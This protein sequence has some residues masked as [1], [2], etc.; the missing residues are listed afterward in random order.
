MRRAPLLL[1]LLLF[2][3][4]GARPDETPPFIGVISPGGGAIA[5]GK[6]VE[7]TGYA[8]DDTGVESV[9]ASG[10]EVLAKGQ[11]G[12]RL[13]RFR[14]RLEAPK[15][16]EVRVPLV[17]RD[18]AGHRREKTLTLVLDEAPPKVRVERVEAVD[19][20]MRVVGV[21]TDDVEVDRVVVQYGK[22]YARLNLP[23]GKS[24]RFFVEVPAKSARVI[25]VDAV[26]QRG[27]AAVKLDQSKKTR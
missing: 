18:K 11:R 7:V 8:F 15:A 20:R 17:A 3:A 6:G 9:T 5:K 14:F 4:C 25:A 19:D 13:V 12:R 26:G 22:T 10:T 2:T 27:E 21:A 23:K 1:L 24:V 16:G